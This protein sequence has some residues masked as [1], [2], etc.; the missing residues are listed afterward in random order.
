LDPEVIAARAK[1][2]KPR[3]ESLLPKDSQA[4]TSVGCAVVELFRLIGRFITIHR[5][6]AV[7]NTNAV[8]DHFA[9]L[10]KI[11]TAGVLMNGA[12]T[13]QLGKFF[14]EPG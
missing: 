3:S 1:P 10:R 6:I 8:I 14:D 11:V 2:D 7:D 9:A 12:A 5:K 13:A 4:K